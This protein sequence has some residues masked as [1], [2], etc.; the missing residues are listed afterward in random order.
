MQK[1]VVKP[2]ISLAQIVAH[3]GFVAKR[4]A[5]DLVWG[6]GVMQAEAECGAVNAARGLLLSLHPDIEA[7]YGD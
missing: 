3:G 6:E 5:A 2:D 7:T 4:I 1:G